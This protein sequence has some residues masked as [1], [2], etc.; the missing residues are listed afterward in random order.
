MNEASLHM[1]T[2]V[3]ADKTT[4]AGP[5]AG[6]QPTNLARDADL[7]P[8]TRP[9]A[10][11]PGIAMSASLAIVIVLYACSPNFARHDGAPHPFAGDFV[12]E[13]IGGWLVW[14]GPTH[15]MYDF[16]FVDR[17]EHDPEVIG[18]AW[19]RDVYLPLVYPP[20][21]YACVAP[22]SRLPF[23]VAAWVW[24][25]LMT[26]AFYAAVFVTRRIRREMSSARTATTGVDWTW[27]IPLALLF[28]PMLENLASS[29]KATL[30]LFLLAATWYLLQRDRVY[31]A[32][33]VCGCLAFKPQ[34]I[35]VL[36]ACMVCLRAGR[37]LAGFATTCLVLL[38][39]SLWIGVD[40]CWNYAAFTLHADDYLHTAGY[41]LHRNHCLYGC[42]ALLSGG[43]TDGW[44][45]LVTLAGM[46]W[47]GWRLFVLLRGG[48]K[49]NEPC[50]PAQL[51]GILI[52]TV[53][54]SPH[55][56]T[57]DLSLLLLPMALLLMQRTACDGAV[58]GW[59]ITFFILCGIAAPIALATN[60]Q[61]TTPCLLSALY[62]LDHVRRAAVLP[63]G[64]ALPHRPM[65]FTSS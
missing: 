19:S 20:F 16:R 64:L 17:L 42:L 40:V 53:L 2:S 61:L 21:Y 57:Y 59:S 27:L 60:V 3:S 14:H 9:A 58:L 55:W 65:G 33:L 43:T 24:A 39:I 41:D 18:F 37:F 34:W 15:R 31:L 12:Q 36:V 49:P 5:F 6:L 35:L 54:C 13:W 50:G 62:Y 29:Q 7:L 51:A 47:I 30:G 46:V 26:A 38:G 52:A 4:P 22:L 48:L 23:H 1:G 11:R 28:T 56:L 32:G 45:R 63:Q 44:V 10:T 25:A 8:A